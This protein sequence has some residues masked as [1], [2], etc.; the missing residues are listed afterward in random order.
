MARAVIYGLLALLI[1]AVA[2][3]LWFRG[4]AVLAQGSAASATTRADAAEAEARDLRAAL[5]TEREGT[6][7]MS[8]IGEAHETD[9]SAA[10]SVPATVVAGL[11]SGDLQLRQHWAACETS[12][13]SEAAAATVERDAAAKRREA[14]FGHLVRV[15]RDVDDQLHACQAVVRQY[16]D[17]GLTT[18][19]GAK[20]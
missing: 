7:A 9:R 18:R 14:D 6:Q 3:L 12:R 11:R 13:L 17:A 15:G 16:A 19:D 20:P 10:E 8:I 1:A 5:A 4:E 2:G